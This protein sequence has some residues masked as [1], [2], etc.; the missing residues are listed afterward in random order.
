MKEKILIFSLKSLISVVQC[1]L[2]GVTLSCLLLLIIIYFSFSTG[3]EESN[4]IISCIGLSF[5]LAS[6][7]MQ[8]GAFV[9]DDKAVMFKR[10]WLLLFHATLLFIFSLINHFFVGLL[11]EVINVGV[12]K[13]KFYVLF[14]FEI[15]LK[16][17]LTSLLIFGILELVWALHNLNA[18]LFKEIFFSEKVMKD[19]WKLNI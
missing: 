17:S 4:I 10:I 12:E 13:M 1:F 19:Q 2:N 5:I 7:S 18:L 8:M 14:Y 9:T 15:I 16:L 6:L 3:V 11:D